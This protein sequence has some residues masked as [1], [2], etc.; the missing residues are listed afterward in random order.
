MNMSNN[1]KLSFKEKFCYALGDASANIAWRGVAA[2]LTI[3]YT[4]VFGLT[5]ATVAMIMLICRAG[6]GVSDVFMGVVGDRTTSRHGHFRPWVLWTAIPLGVILSLLFTAP[7]WSNSMKIA[8]AYVTYILFTLIYT[9]NNIPYGALM[10]VMTPSENERASLGAFRMAGAFTGG[11]LVQGALFMLVNYF[12]E[13]NSKIEIEKKAET[14]YVVKITSPE[15]VKSA[16]IKT[17]HGPLGLY[18]S[19]AQFQMLGEAVPANQKNALSMEAD[20][21]YRF[22]IDGE[23]GLTVNDIKLVDEKTGAAPDSGVV[24]LYKISESK[25]VAEMHSNTLPVE[26][27]SFYINRDSLSSAATIQV[28]SDTSEV[29]K[30][31]SFPI[32]ANQ[33]YSF[34]V[35]GE[36]DLTVDDFSLVNQ[37]TGYSHSMYILSAILALC[38]FFTF[39]GTRER[40][41]PPKTQQ[42][43]LKEDLL[44]LIQNKPWVILLVVGLGFNIYN[45]MKTIIIPFYFTHY[46]GN[47]MLA[48]VYFV[49]LMIVSI[50]GASITPALCD[51]FG[52]KNVFLGSMVVTSIINSFLCVFEPNQI[53]AIFVV[54]MLSELFAAI[55]PT[56]FFGM[57]GDAADYGEKMFGRRA[58][59]LVYSAGSFATKFGG[60][61]AGAIIGWVLGGFGY[62]GTDPNTIR[63]AIPGIVMLMSWIPAV[64]CIVF[65]I[66]M[67]FYPSQAEF[68]ALSSKSVVNND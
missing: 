47:P 7:D 10:A 22:V 39:Y 40:I 51:K 56:L 46:M 25:Y 58:T 52:K 3:F 15:N 49:M 35:M 45:N 14:E 4:D 67:K 23:A 66:V 64:I 17:T 32:V 21:K 37:S 60:G 48:G 42:N 28:V 31:R 57:L 12:G 62:E 9:A 53:L 59:G 68:D 55:L 24:N 54:G 13:I 8:Y 50:I 20:Q 19:C 26:N 44:N 11:M 43:N 38:M 61:I 34:A 29:G 63:E 2:F 33:T 65:A 27:A 30:G 5:P 1:G 6:D 36:K 18:G 16:I 41:E